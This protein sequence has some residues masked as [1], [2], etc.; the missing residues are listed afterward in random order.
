[1]T[2]RPALDSG[3]ESS[4]DSDEHLIDELIVEA[5]DR[6]PLNSM[7]GG[8]PKTDQLVFVK[9][10]VDTFEGCAGNLE[11]KFAKNNGGHLRIRGSSYF[12][13]SWRAE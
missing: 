9:S 5:M 3:C 7:V 4:I 13:G 2:D 8:G 11:I 10:D 12:G 1:M 6:G